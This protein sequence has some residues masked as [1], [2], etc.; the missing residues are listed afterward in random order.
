[1][2]WGRGS[3]GRATVGVATLLALML[4][5]HHPLMGLMPMTS[6]AGL[7]GQGMGVA[8]AASSSAMPPGGASAAVAR[9]GARD[10]SDCAACTMTCPLMN[11][12]TPDRTALRSPGAQR[13][14]RAP[15]PHTV[16]VWATSPS[17][18]AARNVAARGAGP[19]PAQRTRRAILQVYLL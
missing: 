16:A 14:G 19:I 3:D 8:M 7:S 15:W 17:A 11:M 10:V 12:I 9:A 1:M 6:A 13:E 4:M 5:L 18:Y 2:G